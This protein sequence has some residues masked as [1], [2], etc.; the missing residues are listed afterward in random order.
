M[1]VLKL[2]RRLHAVEGCPQRD[3]E[4]IKRLLTGDGKFY[5]FGLD[6]Y[7]CAAIERMPHNPTADQLTIRV[8]AQSLE[9]KNGKV[10]PLRSYEEALEIIAAHERGE[11]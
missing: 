1:P 10:G 5:V 9:S 3:G 6:G 11:L 7:G 4:P 8:R 2:K